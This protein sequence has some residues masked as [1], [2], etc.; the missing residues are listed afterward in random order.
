ML[1]A[2]VDRRPVGFTAQSFTSVSLDP[3]LVAVSVARTS[4]SWVRIRSKGVFCASILADD[5]EPVARGF[6]TKGTDRFRT[7]GWSPAAG[8]GSPVIAGSLAWVDCRIMAEHDGG[9]HLL[10]LARVVDLGVSEGRGPLLFYRGGY[11]RFSV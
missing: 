9:D 10:V 4:Q 8:T 1:A 7:V 2:V 11:G 3:P 6:A 5:Q